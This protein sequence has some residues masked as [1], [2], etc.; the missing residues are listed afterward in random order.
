MRRGA[1]DALVSCDFPIARLQDGEKPAV[2]AAA[3]LVEQ[4]GADLVKIDGAATAPHIVQAVT[5]A[6]IPVWAQFGIT[7]HNAARKRYWSIWW[8]PR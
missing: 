8:W 2:A 6:G 1:P 4:G 7:P 5:R 3:A